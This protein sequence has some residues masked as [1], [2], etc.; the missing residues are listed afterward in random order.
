MNQSRQAQRTIKL[1]DEAAAR[2]RD[3]RD[4]TRFNP[5]L[6]VE[7]QA[8]VDAG[9][10]MIINAADLEKLVDSR[11]GKSREKHSRGD[12]LQATDIIKLEQNIG[13]LL[14]KIDSNDNY[15]NHFNVEDIMALR[16]SHCNFVKGAL[17][18]NC[19]N[20]ARIRSN[21]A[22]IEAI[23]EFVQRHREMLVEAGH[24][25]VPM[26]PNDRRARLVCTP[27]KAA[28]MNGGELHG[29]NDY[30]YKLYP[31]GVTY[32]PYLNMSCSSQSDKSQ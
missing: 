10:V 23:A 28:S 6:K 31:E 8:G 2:E 18:I 21:T 9:H 30:R 3:T 19:D 17:Y 7:I 29:L 15:G 25:V 1:A 26:N 11:I 14:S 27:A 16:E 22:N 20:A 24:N 5:D 12:L 13:G 32:I 4:K